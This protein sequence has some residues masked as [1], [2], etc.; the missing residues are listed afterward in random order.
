MPLHYIHCK[1]EFAIMNVQDYGQ[2]KTWDGR[3]KTKYN[4]KQR[5]NTAKNRAHK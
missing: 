1:G 5:R 4:F 3:L 2:M